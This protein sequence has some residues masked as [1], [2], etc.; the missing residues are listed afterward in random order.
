MLISWL[1]SLTG[2][3][4]INTHGKHATKRRYRYRRSGFCSSE[5]E[6]FPAPMCAPLNS[7]LKMKKRLKYISCKYL[8]I[9]I[10]QVVHWS[11]QNSSLNLIITDVPS[12]FCQS[13]LLLVVPPVDLPNL[14]HHPFPSVFH[15][16]SLSSC[17]LVSVTPATASTLSVISLSICVLSLL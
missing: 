6:L 3:P 12:G 9:Q 4:Q 8:D 5:R 14:P 1:I 16:I 10:P 13:R 11:T 7:L 17:L 15:I 2:F